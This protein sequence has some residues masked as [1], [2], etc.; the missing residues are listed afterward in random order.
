VPLL[1]SIALLSP[2]ISRLWIGHIAMP[3]VVLTVI[4]S[5]GWLGNLIATPAFLLGV[6]TGYI[7]W[8]LYGSCLTTAGACG[9]GFILGHMFGGYG[10]AAAASLMQAMGSLL[11]MRKNC[12]AY[13]ISALPEAG[14]FAA[15]GQKIWH[16]VKTRK[17]RQVA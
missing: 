9:L 14:D 1:V 17:W 13:D 8:N 7:R 6:G 16:F 12:R 5:L 3:F 2:L 15:A 4:L 11:S 10:V